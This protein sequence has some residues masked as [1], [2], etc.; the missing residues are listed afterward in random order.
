[1]L[2]YRSGYRIS[3]LSLHIQ[4]IPLYY[5]VHRL[6]SADLRVTGMDGFDHRVQVDQNVAPISNFFSL[7]HAKHIATTTVYLT[8][9]AS[10]GVSISAMH[11]IS[12]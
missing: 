10:F 3:D 9:V 7:S 12:T 1:M 11:P 4:A 2:G 5:R 6:G 8:P